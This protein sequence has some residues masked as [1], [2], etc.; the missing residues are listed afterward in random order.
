MG[1][2]RDIKFIDEDGRPTSLEYAMGREITI[3][4]SEPG[5]EYTA[6]LKPDDWT[7]TRT[8]CFCCSCGDFTSDPACRNHGFAAKRP[9]E[10]HNMPG[11]V[12]DELPNEDG[13]IPDWCGTMPES[14]QEVRKQRN[15]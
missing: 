12:W 14:V 2:Y 9:C 1:I 6:K 13:S 8:N 11:S 7:E 4:V 5:L 15:E 10:T 3:S